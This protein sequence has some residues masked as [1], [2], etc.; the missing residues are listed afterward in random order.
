MIPYKQVAQK[1]NPMAIIGHRPIEQIKMP[2]K[3]LFTSSNCPVSFLQEMLYLYGDVTLS[4]FPK[5]LNGND[6]SHK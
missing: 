2:N 5:C 6:V 4:T 3:K 1:W